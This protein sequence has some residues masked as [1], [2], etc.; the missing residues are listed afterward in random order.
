MCFKARMIRGV[1]SMIRDAVRST[2]IGKKQTPKK[3]TKFRRLSTSTHFPTARHHRVSVTKPLGCFSGQ[4]RQL[5]SRSRGPEELRANLRTHWDA[6]PVGPPLEPALIKLHIDGNQ[7]IW[8]SPV[9]VDSWNPIIYGVFIH[10]RWLALGFLNHQQ[11]LYCFLTAI[12]ISIW[13]R[14]ANWSKFLGVVVQWYSPSIKWPAK[15]LQ[16]LSHLASS[17]RICEASSYLPGSK[18]NHTGER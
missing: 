5:S 8:R 3:P 12:N 17:R 14:V 15:V 13:N 16:Y 18:K 7:Q 11:Y 4:G 1:N 6:C 10:P 9:E 2:S